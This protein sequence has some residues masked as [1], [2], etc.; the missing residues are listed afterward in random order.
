MNK[1]TIAEA[2]KQTK[3][4]PY[5]DGDGGIIACQ[6]CGSVEYLYNE[7]GNRCSFCGQCGQAIDWDG[8]AGEEAE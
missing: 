6:T 1:E 8:D 2:A 5:P 4:S 3:R 7:D